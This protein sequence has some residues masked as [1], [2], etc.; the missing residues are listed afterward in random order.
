[1][2]A[3]KE[4]IR[5]TKI[6]QRKKEKFVQ[7]FGGK[8]QMC[9]FDS[10]LAALTFHHVSG[11]KEGDPCRFIGSYS[12]ERIEKELAKCVLLCRNCHSIVHYNKLD[13]TQYVKVWLDATCPTCR[14]SFKTKEDE[15]LY[16]SRTCSQLSQR[17]TDRP[18]K[19][20]LQKLVS[21]T[22]WTQIGRMYGVSDNAVR[23]WAKSYKLI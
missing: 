2:T 14:K 6:R 20:E 21:E 18:T 11:K 23:K 22:S 17:K 9:G 10:C 3:N 8:C 16:C 12:D 19:D 5:R 13:T 15:Q 1:M 7:R 4:S